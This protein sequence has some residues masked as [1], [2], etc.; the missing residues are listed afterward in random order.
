MIF[1]ENTLSVN[2]I[3]IQKL[4]IIGIMRDGRH[5]ETKVWQ[6]ILFFLLS[7]ENWGH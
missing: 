3:R 5:A 7:F 1:I 2:W 4:H 6:S